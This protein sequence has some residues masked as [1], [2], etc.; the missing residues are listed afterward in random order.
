MECQCE[1]CQ[2]LSGLRHEDVT[3]EMTKQLPRNVQRILRAQVHVL[4][5]L[6]HLG[7]EEL[8]RAAARRCTAGRFEAKTT[9]Q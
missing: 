4:L 1:V 7:D 3:K 5:R 9:I 2:A 6:P 8:V